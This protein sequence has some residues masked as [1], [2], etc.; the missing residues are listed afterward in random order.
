MRLTVGLRI[1]PLRQL[2]DPLGRRLL[3]H[4]R[5]HAVVRR[6]EAVVA[7]VDGNAAT[8]RSH[9]RID[10]DEKNR[11]RWKVFVAGGKLERRRH[12]VVRREC[13]A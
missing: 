7:R 6:D 5:Q 8:R 11:A 9:S 10:D 13:R 4:R 1:A 3:Q 12:H 2:D